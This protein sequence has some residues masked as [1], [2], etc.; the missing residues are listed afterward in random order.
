MMFIGCI[1]ACGVMLAKHAQYTYNYEHGMAHKNGI[2]GA[3]Q[4]FLNRRSANRSINEGEGTHQDD[5]VEAL[6]EP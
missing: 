1:L 4:L 5:T 2:N 6:L 3:S